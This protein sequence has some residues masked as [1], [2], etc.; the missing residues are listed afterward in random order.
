[1]MRVLCTAFCAMSRCAK[2]KF[3]AYG[4]SLVCF[5]VGLLYLLTS[6][7]GL[8]VLE[9]V[10][11]QNFIGMLLILCCYVVFAFPL[12]VSLMYATLGLCG[13]FLYGWLGL[14]V[15]AVSAST[16]IVIATVLLRPW[17]H[18]ILAGKPHAASFVKSLDEYGFKFV[19]LFRMAPLP[20]GIQNAVVS[21]S[22]LPF[23][24]LILGS[25][26]GLLPEQCLTCYV[27]TTLKDL[28]EVA[29]GDSND[30]T[31]STIIVVAQI[32]AA[33]IVITVM[34]IVARREIRKMQRRHE[35]AARAVFAGAAADD[36]FNDAAAA[37]A[38]TS[39]DEE[40]GGD[41]TDAVTEDDVKRQAPR[42]QQQQQREQQQQEQDLELTALNVSSIDDGN[43]EG[44]LI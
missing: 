40:K 14:L 11:E 22:S 41:D 25:I 13:G 35:E 10:D 36:E 7:V 4:V 1:M 30:Q 29:S 33:V 23:W 31:T 24:K 9:W 8:R 28:E 26:C 39:K 16:G 42:Q 38:T 37:A 2:F 44:I 19:M 6:G 17:A 5:S 27:G 43:D 20:Y 32:L 15:T 12:P 18:R 21:A 3:I 34:V